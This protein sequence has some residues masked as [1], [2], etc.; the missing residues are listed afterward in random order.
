MTPP[1]DLDFNPMKIACILADVIKREPDV[2]LVF[3]GRQADNGSNG[4]TGQLLAEMLSWPCFTMVID[5]KKVE[6]EYQVSRMVDEGI[7][8][9]YLK[10][11]FVITVT[12]SDNKLLRMAGLKAVLEAKKK[13]IEHLEAA[14]LSDF[15][16][17]YNLEELSINKPDKHCVFIEDKPAESK[18]DQLK[19]LLKNRGR[20]E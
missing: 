1:G 18:A 14:G 7:E 9:L 12:Q 5:I 6:D 3:C 13:P 11:P 17:L 20:N 4:Q 15:A 10:A 19:E 16:S 2:E 8:H